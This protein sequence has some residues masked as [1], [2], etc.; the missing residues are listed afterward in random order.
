M[1]VRIRESRLKILMEKEGIKS[2]AELSRRCDMEPQ[3]LNR[4]IKG[5]Q[6]S[7]GGTTIDKLCRILNAQP[8]DFLY[9]EPD[10]IE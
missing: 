4:A 7:I 1:A 3:S 2:Q 8:G 9:Y 5:R 10:P 6:K